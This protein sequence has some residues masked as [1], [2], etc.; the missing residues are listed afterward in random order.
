MAHLGHIHIQ[1]NIH[2][3]NELL[4]TLSHDIAEILLRLDAIDLPH[5]YIVIQFKFF[6]GLEMQSLDCHHK[7][8]IEEEKHY[9]IDMQR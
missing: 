8:Y 1:I 3:W 9:T 2:N 7:Q 5:S 6:I 4:L